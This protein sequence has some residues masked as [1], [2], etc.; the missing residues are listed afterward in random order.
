VAAA[1]RALKNMGFSRLR[2]VGALPAEELREA[3]GAA[4]GAWDVLDGSAVFADLES[5]LADCSLAFGA[6]GKAPWTAGAGAL[7][8]PSWSPR[9]LARFA[10][11]Q[12]AGT[13]L[14]VVFGPEQRGLT[15][16]E[17]QLCQHVVR[18]PSDPGQA[19]L[20]LAQAVLV[21]AYE[22]FVAGHDER[23]HERA[24]PRPWSER[25]ELESALGHWHEALKEIGY[26]KEPRPGRLLAELRRLLTRARPSRRELDLLRG[27]ARQAA[28]AGRVA[29]ARGGVR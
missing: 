16:E 23:E 21:I 17:L 5:A 9:R 10:T 18:I 15:R 12:P 1:C 7:E 13:R 3:R 4:Y 29:R 24:A 22:L 14:G 25:A 28:W 6:S 20:N 19:S 2:V 11:Q 26:L 8:A 27:V